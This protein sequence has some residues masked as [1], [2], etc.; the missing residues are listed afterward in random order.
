[1]RLM[2]FKR[3]FFVISI[4]LMIPGIICMLL[5]G[6]K[7]GIDF[8]GGNLLEY[9]FE[10]SINRAQLEKFGEAYSSG[11]NSWI[12]K[13]GQLSDSQLSDLKIS[14]GELGSYQVIRE[15]SVG[16]VIG[17]ELEQNAVEAVIVASIVIVGFITLSFRRIPKPTSSFRFG[18]A[19]IVALLHDV[20]VV[21]SLLS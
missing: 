8:T 7:L 10:T 5:G 11:E 21:V 3:W 19:A 9:R 6:L 2:R 14:L 15:E 17:K 4:G 13:T 18:V 12:I 20:I 16:P 1:M